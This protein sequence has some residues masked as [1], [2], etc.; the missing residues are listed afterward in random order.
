MPDTPKMIVDEGGPLVT[1]A[2][3]GGGS[4]DGVVVGMGRYSDVPPPEPP[5]SPQ[6]KKHDPEPV[7]TIQVSR[8]V[9]EA[10]LIRRIVPEYPP[11]ARTARVQGSVQLVA[12]IGR[13]GTVRNIQVMGGHP[14]LLRAAV[15][16][17][18]KWVYSP[19]LLNGAAVEVVAPIDVNFTLS[20]N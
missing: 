16:A 14:L 11:L 2:T 5:K 4:P 6:V 3:T 17:V 13:D 9:Q 1:T 10:K 8:G 7:R 19:T 20:G 18:S 15:D 12:H